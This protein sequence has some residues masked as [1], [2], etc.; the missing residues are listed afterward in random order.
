MAIEQGLLAT[1]DPTA[2]CDPQRYVVS[3]DNPVLRFRRVTRIFYYQV[4]GLMFPSKSALALLGGRE[5]FRN[6]RRVLTVADAKRNPRPPSTRP[7]SRKECFQEN[8]TDRKIISVLVRYPFIR[9]RER[10]VSKHVELGN[11]QRRQIRVEKE[12]KHRRRQIIQHRR[13]Q[14]RDV[15]DVALKCRALLALPRTRRRT[16]KELIMDVNKLLST[17][18][19]DEEQESGWSENFAGPIFSQLRCSNNS[20]NTTPYF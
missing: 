14:M 1:S 18:V 11:K 5:R 7:P 4:S 13:E 2:K 8:L 10:P 6:E 16:R 17:P 9:H 20:P 15:A 19:K 3:T 12:E